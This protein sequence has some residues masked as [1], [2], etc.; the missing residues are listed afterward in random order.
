MGVGAAAIMAGPAAAESWTVTNLNDSGSGSLR[1]ALNSINLSPDVFSTVVFQSGLTGD[2]NLQSPLV[3]FHPVAITGP[4]ADKIALNGGGTQ[5]IFAANETGITPPFT[6]TI[7]D[8]TLKGGH[9]ST[10]GDQGGAIHSVETD[11]TLARDVIS[12]NSTT[13]YGGAIY[14]EQGGSLKIKDTTFSNNSS[15]YGGAL[16][17]IGLPVK[18]D[19]TTFSGNTASHAAGAILLPELAGDTSLDVTNSTF[20][21][22]ST[23]TDS[24]TVGGWGFGGAI[25]G[26]ESVGTASINLKSSTISGNTAASGGGIGGYFTSATVA[27][28]IVGGNQAGAGPDINSTFKNPNVPASPTVHTAFDSSFSLIGNTSAAM[29]NDA[30]AGSNVTGVSPAL[31]P[32][33]DN[34]G[35]TK[36]MQP[37]DTSPVVNKGSTD[38]L[39]DQRALV[40]PVDFNSI[41][42][43]TAAG[44]NGADIGAVELQGGPLPPSCQTDPSLCPPPSNKFS[45]GKVK[46]DK[47]KGMATVQVKVPGAGKVLLAGSKTVKKA[48]ATA[49]AKATLKIKV[50]AKGKAAKA[51]KKKGKAKVKAK[52]TFTPNGGTAAG[53]SRTI[54]LIRKK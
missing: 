19:S 11:L 40:R 8:L 39:V 9:S 16:A 10:A 2:I 53:K 17:A 7:A 27:N 4:G 23:A 43:S 29:I 47:K 31:G 38:L 48:S 5:Q 37:A 34:G 6:L 14:A 41:P 35:F 25:A 52:F 21:G 28:T 36:T 22:N 51:L 3:I 54:K 42:F 15:Q 13:V 12:G 30:V 50:K 49:R 24:S 44:A 33:A 32:L 46:L 45:F 18:I 26:L 1:Q 20:T